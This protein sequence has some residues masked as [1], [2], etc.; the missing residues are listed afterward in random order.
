MEAKMS[1]VYPFSL[2][3]TYRRAASQSLLLCMSVH[4]G[5]DEHV[6]PYAVRRVQHCTGG[7]GEAD[8]DA[9]THGKRL[10]FLAIPITPPVLRPWP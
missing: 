1:V 2:V 3:L 6:S 7:A 8:N 5:L 10:Q 4:S 9:R